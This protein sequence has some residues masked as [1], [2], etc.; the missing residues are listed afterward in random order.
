MCNGGIH[1]PYVAVK[2]NEYKAMLKIV[3]NVLNSLQV[4]PSRSIGRS[5]LTTEKYSTCI[6]LRKNVMKTS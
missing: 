4:L 5:V 1:V 3:V 6:F 2:N